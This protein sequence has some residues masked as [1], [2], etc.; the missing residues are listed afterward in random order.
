MPEATFW[1]GKRVFVTGHTGFKGAWLCLWLHRLGAAVTGYALPPPTDPS[2][3]Q[4]ARVQE[5]I[6]GRTGD[7]RDGEALP[8]AMRDSDPEILFHLAA[9]PIVREGYA[10]PLETLEVN[11][12]GTARLLECARGMGSLRAAVIVTTD[13]CYRNGEEARPF[14]EGD[15]L[16]GGDPYSASKA[17]AEIVAEAY[18]ESFFA[19]ADSPGIATARAGNV[20]GGG[21]FAK[22]RIV[23]DILRAWAAGESARLRNPE[24][25]R[26]WQDVLEPLGGYLL[27]AERLF[28]DKEAYA[29]AY[30]FGPALENCKDVA[31]IAEALCR[32]LGCRTHTGGAQGPREAHTLLL[33]SA[34][35]ARVLGWRP[36]FSLEETFSHIADFARATATGEGARGLCCRHIEAYESA[37]ARHG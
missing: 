20:I 4:M 16:G 31:H 12:M 23:P 32:A 18:R 11:A 35:A 34:K 26:P 36:V 13:K 5:L 30:N 17:C 1:K 14:R 6:D 25:V 37:Q 29:G 27:L 15:P 9:Q 33:D 21:D 3:Y 24:A 28:R 8:R 2:L 22:D 7:I 19:R 10:R